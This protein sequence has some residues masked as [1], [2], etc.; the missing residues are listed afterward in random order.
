MFPGRWSPPRITTHRCH[1]MGDGSAPVMDDLMGM[2]RGVSWRSD[3][4]VTG[5]FVGFGREIL[6]RRRERGWLIPPA[7]P[8]TA[9][10]GGGTGDDICIAIDGDGGRGCQV[11]VAKESISNTYIFICPYH[12]PPCTPPSD[13]CHS[14]CC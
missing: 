12:L 10:S 14:R 9:T 8:R 11:R 1:D 6:Q 5:K 2:V 13:Y 3:D 7:A 4:V